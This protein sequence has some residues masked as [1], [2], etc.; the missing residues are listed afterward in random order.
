MRCVSSDGVVGRPRTVWL[1]RALAFVIPF[2]LAFP[3]RLVG[4]FFAGEILA[5]SLVPAA[6][7]CRRWILSNR[8]I[9]LLLGTGIIWLGSLV[10]SDIWR[11]TSPN[12]SMRGW[13]EIAITLMMLVVLR[14]LIGTDQVRLRIALAGTVS[15]IAVQLLLFPTGPQQ[16]APWSLGGAWAL[17]VAVLLTLPLLPRPF[18]RIEPAL[19]LLPLGIFY[20]TQ[21]ARNAGGVALIAAGFLGVVHLSRY[22]ARIRGIPTGTLT[23][24]QITIG[25]LAISIL[26][27]VVLVA[28]SWFATSGS[29]GSEAAERFELQATGSFGLLVG[30]RQGNVASLLAI[31]DSPFIGHGS[32]AENREYSE[33]ARALLREYG[34]STVPPKS[35]AIPTHS[36][37]LGA[38]VTAGIAGIAFWLVTLAIAIG[39]LANAARDSITMAGHNGLSCVRSDVGLVVLTVRRCWTHHLASDASRLD[40]AG[41]TLV[42]RSVNTG[43]IPQR[44]SHRFPART[45]EV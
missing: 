10:L 24:R 21:S 17:T 43:G 27:G 5:L 39:T 22:S 36:Y 29:L 2:L 7:V 35:D 40:Q 1:G 15:G 26:A 9:R 32:R 37:V 4:V 45:N 42:T 44:F 33:S 20:I 14:I 13:G 8:S 25:A 28:Y 18:N 30:G 16:A 6:I 34:Y 31:A 38:W 3:L 41:F 19:V 11:G 23:A 12:A